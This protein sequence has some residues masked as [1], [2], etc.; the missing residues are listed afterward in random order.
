M[1]T[2]GS[3]EPTASTFRGEGDEGSRFLQNVSNFLP[4]YMVSCSWKHYS[5]HCHKKHKSLTLCKNMR[6][7]WQQIPRA[8]LPEMW[9]WTVWLVQIF[10]RNLL[11][12]PSGKKK[13]NAPDCSEMLVPNYHTS[14]PTR[15]QYWCI[16]SSFV[17]YG[18]QLPHN[19]HIFFR[20]IK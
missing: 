7:L 5:C 9:C 14:H 13:M 15:L 1:F 12:L 4:D 3:D 10:Q 8:Q 19:T 16:N 17:V 2:C 20:C 6:L 11:L 18:I